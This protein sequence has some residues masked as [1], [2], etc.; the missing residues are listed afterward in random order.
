ML[1]TLCAF[2]ALAQSDGLPDRPPKLAGAA[3]LSGRPVTPNPSASKAMVFVFISHDC[4]IANRYAPEIARIYSDYK[5]QKVAFY[6]VYVGSMEEAALYA[7][8]GKEF[9]LSM[10]G[11]V[12]YDLKLARATGAT[13]TPE[14]VVLD[15]GGVMR[16]RG[17][18]DD[19]NIEHGKIRDGYRRDLRIALD[20]ILAGKPVSVPTTAAVGCFIP[21]GTQAG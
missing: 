3:D 19:Q 15:Q 10:P 13:V 4:P 2:A 18:I 16:Y 12:D 9:G 7:E 11:L 20:E 14:A 1:A 21:F 17:R 8:H 6:R 5:S